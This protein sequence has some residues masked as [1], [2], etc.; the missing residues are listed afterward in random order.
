MLS[1]RAWVYLIGAPFLI[2]ALGFVVQVLA[3]QVRLATQP[4]HWYA[5]LANVRTG[6]VTAGY[7]MTG[8]G[9]VYS[10]KRAFAAVVGPLASKGT[11]ES[12][13]KRPSAAGETCM[14]LTDRQAADTDAPSI[15]SP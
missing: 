11:C 6:S 9:F 3:Q 12:Y 13:P 15:E 2:I 5:T 14:E 1:R 10:S 8:H 4:H 7:K